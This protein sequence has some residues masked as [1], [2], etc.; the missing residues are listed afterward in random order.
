MKIAV[1]GKSRSGKDTLCELWRN[2]FGLKFTSSSMAACDLFIFDRLSP[3][4]GYCSREECYADRIN[5]RALWFKLISDY[6]TPDKTKLAKEILNTNDCYNG[7]RCIE[8][9]SMAR[10]ENLFDL[11]IW[12]DAEKRIRGEEP[13]PNMVTSNMADVIIKN[14]SCKEDYY[15]R[16][17]RLGEQL[18]K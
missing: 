5:H 9:L 11:I 18:F 7:M 4:K 6:N 13:H 1:L 14:D 3:L 15:H 12:V 10:E 2:H 16:A 17:M 8:E